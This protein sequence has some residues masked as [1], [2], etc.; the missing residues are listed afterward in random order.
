MAAEL[1]SQTDVI[2]SYSRGA[3]LGWE[4]GGVTNRLSTTTP[5]FSIPQSDRSL[6]TELRGRNTSWCGTVGPNA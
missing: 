1:S 4:Y 3:Q 2:T 6:A 5:L